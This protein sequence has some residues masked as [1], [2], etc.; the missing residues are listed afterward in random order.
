MGLGYLPEELNSEIIRVLRPGSR[1]QYFYTSPAEEEELR[2]R[3]RDLG[4]PATQHIR[5][6]TILPQPEMTTRVSY[7]FDTIIRRC[8]AKMAFNY[9]AY[10]LSEDSRLLLRADFDR[11]RT[12]VRDGTLAE[13]EIVSPIGSPRLTEE[14]R[15]GSLVDGHM[16]GVGWSADENILCNLSIFNA[17]TY[18][19]LLCPKV[20]GT[21]VCVASV[22]SFDFKTKEA[23]RLPADLWVPL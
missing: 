11:V 15:K 19:V 16:I 12:F 9:L 18:Q 20:S 14:S 5:K 8:V 3:L 22:H 2:A 4:F 21:L 1:V 17:M 6:D 23:K 7:L 13:D 10:A